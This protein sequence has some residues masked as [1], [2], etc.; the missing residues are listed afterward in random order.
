MHAWNRLPT[1]MKSGS[2][3]HGIIHTQMESHLDRIEFARTCTHTHHVHTRNADARN[4]VSMVL[5]G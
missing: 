2:R 3:L 1:R 4:S 5:D